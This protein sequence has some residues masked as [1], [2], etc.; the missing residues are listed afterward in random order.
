MDICIFYEHAQRELNNA[1]LLKF[2]L[3]RRGY[4]VELLK[5]YES[6]IPYFNKPKLVITPWMYDYKYSDC[7][8][9]CF[10]RGF[11]K[12]LNLQYEQVITKLWLERGFHCPSDLAQNASHICWSDKIKRRLISVGVSDKNCFVAGDLK[13]DFSKYPFKKLYRDKKELAHEFNIPVGHKWNIFISSFSLINLEKGTSLDVMKKM[14]EN[15]YGE[16]ESIQIKSQKEIVKWIEKFIQE[17]LDVEFIYRPHPSEFENEELLKLN[18]KYDNFHYISKYS[19]QDWI[20]NCDVINTWYSTSLIEIFVLG[21]SC[22]ILRP[23]KLN[24][25]FDIPYMIDAVHVEDYNS[26]EKNNI[27]EKGNFP[28][29]KESLDEYYL[30]NDDFVYKKIA[31]RVELMIQSDEYKGKF[32]K[33]PPFLET[34]WLI[35]SRVFSK[36]F[37]ILIKGFLFK[38]TSQT[39]NE[40]YW[41]EKRIK[42]LKE[43]VYNE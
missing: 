24:K 34:F 1:Y 19:I 42:K 5:L 36:H 4:G 29:S 43:F 20:V 15:N 35:L 41:S 32:Y 17:H 11:D 30:I 14:G 40:D 22:N 25:Y 37:F 28:V 39:D 7:F 16:L 8:R 12:V 26:F 13:T 38:Q 6:K 9:V 27:E 2:E 31:D 3:E 18:E 33:Y 23:F 10:L 21:K